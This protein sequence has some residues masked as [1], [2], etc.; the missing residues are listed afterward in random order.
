MVAR[1]KE[2]GSVMRT[3]FAGVVAG[4]VTVMTR[5]VPPTCVMSRMPLP[6]A[7]TAIAG[8]TADIAPGKVVGMVAWA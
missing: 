8:M 3:S 7:R 6:S 4:Q 5:M 2:G 1:L